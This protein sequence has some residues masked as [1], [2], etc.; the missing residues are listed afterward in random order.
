MGCL[1]IS[2]KESANWD[3]VADVCS[4]SCIEVLEV[5]EAQRTHLQHNANV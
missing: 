4:D 3:A 5:L 1:H 2:A